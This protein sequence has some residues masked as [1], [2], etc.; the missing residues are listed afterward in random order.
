MTN[1]TAAALLELKRHRRQL[2]RQQLLTLRGQVLAGNVTAAMKGL[3]KI[4]RRQNER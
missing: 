3:N 2:T 1:D 4:L